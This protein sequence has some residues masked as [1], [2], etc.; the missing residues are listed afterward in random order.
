MRSSHH[1]PRRASPRD[2]PPTPGAR[3][4]RPFRARRVALALAI[5]QASWCAARPA[6][7]SPLFT[8]S[9][10]SFETGRAP[11]SVVMKDLNGDGN[12]D[13]IAANVMANSVS[14]L[15]GDGDAGFSV[16]VDYATGVD[17][18]HIAV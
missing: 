17:P 13:L 3:M 12:L 11:G 5:A 9:Y 6:A 10:L 16:H 4:P 2:P 18:E 14:V 1:R 7:A 8:A 15:L